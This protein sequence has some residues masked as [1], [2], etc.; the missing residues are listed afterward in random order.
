VNP[1][2]DPDGIVRRTFATREDPK[3][4]HIVDQETEQDETA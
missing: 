1:A 2:F 3:A 4:G